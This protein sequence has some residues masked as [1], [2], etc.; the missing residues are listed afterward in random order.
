MSDTRKVLV[1]K[2]EAVEMAKG[3]SHQDYKAIKHMNKI[4]LAMYLHHIYT[5]GFED[6]ARSVANRPPVEHEDTP[7]ENCGNS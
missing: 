2:P 5:R 3:I 7:D 6:G 4:E 1:Y